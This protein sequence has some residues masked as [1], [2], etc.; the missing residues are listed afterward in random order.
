MRLKALC[1]L[2]ILGLLS[3]KQDLKEK[4]DSV[5]A[6]FEWEN[7]DPESQ[8]FS[9]EKIEDLISQLSDKG[10][11]KLLII[12]NDKI[13][14]E[15]T[16]EDTTTSIHQTGK[17]SFSNI[18]AGGLP[19]L[20][21][22]DDGYIYPDEPVCRY[23][24]TWRNERLKH[25]VS[26][27]HLATHTSGLQNSEDTDSEK[28]E[29]ILK[30]SDPQPLERSFMNQSSNYILMARDNARII[31]RPGTMYHFS[32]PGLALLS[33]AIT[34]S[35]KD[36]PYTNIRTFLK[37][38]ILDPI[39]IEENEY[40]IGA[41]QTIPLDGLELIPDWAGNK[42]SASAIAKIG[43]LMLHKGKWQGRQVIKSSIVES[44]I[45]PYRVAVPSGSGNNGKT[46]LDMDNILFLTPA[47]GWY[48]NHN[49]A[50]YYLPRDA[51]MTGFPGGDLLLV[52][53]SLNI[54]VVRLGDA[55]IDDLNKE[56]FWTEAEEYLFNPLM[57]ALVQ[58][59][60]P[61]SDLISSVEFASKETVIR[62]ADGSD[63][64][65]ITWADDDNL[66]T[67]FGDGNGFE[68]FTEF[69]ASMGIAMVKGTPPEI[70]GVNIRTKSAEIPG[71]GAYGLKACGMLM[72]DKI[73]YMFVRNAGNSQLAWSSD[74]GKTWE[75]ADW[76][77][78]FVYPTFVNYGRN[79]EGAKDDYV[80]I[81]S[82]DNESNPSA[83]MN[84]DY[85]VLARVHKT[86]VKDWRKYEYFAGYSNKNKP[87]WS[88]DIRKRE[89]VFTNPGRCY[90]SGI[91]YNPGLKRYLWCQTIGTPT[92]AKHRNHR[93]RGGLGIFESPT[94]WG[95]WKTVYYTLDWDIGPGETSSIPPKWMSDD[96]K[97]CYFLFSGDDYFSVRKMTLNNK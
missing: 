13:I 85:M 70:E 93:F 89:P 8:G 60:Y 87:I 40:E 15:W 86:K 64:W 81:Y 5:S 95:P 48:N 65:P 17:D 96:G 34:T 7:A 82:H 47:M 76:Y 3:C 72:V 56:I 92:G 68:P 63:T 16:R 42:F 1:F 49:G 30:K 54:I 37:D 35:L 25:Q 80:Y 2:I 22:I 91:S 67:A 50:I 77:F 32:I 45:S 59:P 33:Y 57:E 97:T 39:G 69:K 46:T 83:Y 12:R 51:F 62:L 41:G 31:S 84:S 55:I 11:K 58:P 53:P 61:Q 94:P 90:R 10:T 29:N 19:L 14:S 73:L 66:Y 20:A 75:W 88:E 43:R 38:R 4:E 27:R 23:L 21:A 6:L 18:F 28:E 78:E 71:D 26:I 74:Y 44:A 52:I 24:P 36:S 79:Y 9:S